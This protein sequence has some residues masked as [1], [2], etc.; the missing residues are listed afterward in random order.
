M[1]E[2]GVFAADTLPKQKEFPVGY[3]SNT[4]TSNQSGQHWVAFF[5]TGKSLECFDSFGGN[6]AKYSSYLKE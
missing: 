5:H 6:P 1:N 3:I 4:E 2:V